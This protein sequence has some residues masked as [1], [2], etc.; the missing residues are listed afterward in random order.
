MK[1]NEGDVS[2]GKDVPC[3]WVERMNIGKMSILTQVIHRFS[4]IPVKIPVVFFTQIEQTILKFVW[5]HKIQ[6]SQRNLEKETK[7]ETSC[8]LI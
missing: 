6:N 2:K 4:A 7:L 1:E 8:S 3:S 5:N